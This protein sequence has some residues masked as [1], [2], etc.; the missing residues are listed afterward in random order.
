MAF[1]LMAKTK[2]RKTDLKICDDLW[3]K[4]IKIRAWFRCEHCWKT[5]YLNS[6]HL[7]TR[8]NYNTRFDLDNGICLCSW[9][10]TMSRKFSAHQTPLE[11]AERVISKRWQERY[12]NLKAKS[13]QTRDKD[14]D[15]IEKYLIDETNKLIS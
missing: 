9:C 8:N 5:S 10:H 2:K 11:F 13:K 3:S 7:F 4:L 12:D 1:W 6:H 14:Y 15:A